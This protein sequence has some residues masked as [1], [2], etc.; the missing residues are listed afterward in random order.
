[1]LEW[2]VPLDGTILDMRATSTQS[3]GDDRWWA[4]PLSV[5][6]LVALIAWVVVSVSFIGYVAWV[7]RQRTRRRPPPGPGARSQRPAGTPPDA[8]V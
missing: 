3:P 6:A 8:R 1:V 7:R 4:R 5:L 2:T